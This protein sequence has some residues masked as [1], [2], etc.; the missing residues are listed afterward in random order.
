MH[1]RHHGTHAG[2]VG[3][4]T[5][6]LAIAAGALAIAVASRV[7]GRR[8]ASGPQ[9]APAKAF[10]RNGHGW[11]EH[12][13]V[14]RTVTIDRPRHELY[15][16]WR[17]FDAFPR[18]ME[19]VET[20]ERLDDNRSRWTIKAPAGQTVSFTTRIT[21]D[22]QN[23]VIAWESEED[24]EVRNSGRVEFRDA[25]AGRGTQVDLTIAY[26]PP[27]GMIGA[28]AAKLY[29][30]EPQLQARRDLKRFKQLMETGE[31]AVSALRSLHSPA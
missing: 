6:L 7:V 3:L 29:Q 23:E 1:H 9:D 16:T 24:A 5:G 15:Q 30:R 22:R 11:R 27:G 14:G 10:R 28:L 19:N 25:P 8:R 20:V 18:F 17:S 4:G 31:I 12:R 26:D 13:V 2:G 21:E